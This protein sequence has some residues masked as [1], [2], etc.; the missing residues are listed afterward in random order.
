M[1]IDYFQNWCTNWIIYPISTSHNLSFKSVFSML[2]IFL[3]Y[4]FYTRSFR[5]RV[6]LKSS[7][8][9]H[10]IIF[11]HSFTWSDQ[12]PTIEYSLVFRYWIYIINIVTL[13]STYHRISNDFIWPN[14]ITLL[15]IDSEFF[16]YSCRTIS[17]INL[18]LILLCSYKINIDMCCTIFISFSR[19]TKNRLPFITRLF[20]PPISC[21]LRESSC[22]CMYYI[23]FTYKFWRKTYLFY[24]S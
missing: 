7:S 11:K 23:S 9:I 17:F 2:C 1:D 16:C 5:F 6:F 14:R 24:L 19:S 18:N 12:L 20:I 21:I 4:N 8:F 10:C 15:S 13:W 22:S 3:E